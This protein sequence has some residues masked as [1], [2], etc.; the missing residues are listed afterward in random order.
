MWNGAAPSL[1]PMPTIMKISP[2]SSN[3]GAVV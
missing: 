2:N 3:F 1:K